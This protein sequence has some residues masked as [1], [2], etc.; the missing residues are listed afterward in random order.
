MVRISVS[1]GVDCRVEIVSVEEP[2]TFIDVGLK[3]AVAPL[4]NPSTFSVTIP[5]NVESVFDD[6]VKLVVPPAV[7]PPDAG[8]MEREK[9]L[10]LTVPGGRGTLTRIARGMLTLPRV[11]LAVM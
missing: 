2:G 6:T 4:G 8:V 11:Y 7:T 10:V 5:V 9:L 3:F 1:T